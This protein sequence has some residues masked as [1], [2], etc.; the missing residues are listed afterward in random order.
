MWRCRALTF[1]SAASQAPTASTRC[2][3]SARSSAVRRQDGGLRRRRLHW[4]RRQTIAEE[5]DLAP[6][7]TATATSADALV[8]EHRRSSRSRSRRSTARCAR[9]ARITRTS[10]AQP[11]SITARWRCARQA[12]RLSAARPSEAWVP[13]PRSTRAVLGLYWLVCGYGLRAL[14]RFAALAIAIPLLAIPLD[15]WG[16]RPGPRVRTRAA[17]RRREQRQPAARTRGEAHRERRGRAARAPD[18]RPV[19]LRPRGALAARAREALRPEQV[20]A[21]RCSPSADRRRACARSDRQPARRRAPAPAARGCSRS[22]RLPR[23]ALRARGPAGS[24]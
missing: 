23:R 21:A 1:A 20:V 24:P 5:H 10:P 11:T 17:V 14:A 3:S 16:F 15:A 19:L 7:A 2:A 18:R 6:R 13:T 12:G 4:T 8:A 22:G 9:P